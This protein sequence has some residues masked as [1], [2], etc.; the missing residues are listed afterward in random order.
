MRCRHPTAMT[1]AL[2]GGY[3]LPQPMTTSTTA[4]QAPSTQF[5]R[6]NT[7]SN[8]QH[9]KPGGRVYASPA[10]AHQTAGG[11]PELG[12][13]DGH[14]PTNPSRSNPAYG[15]SGDIRSGTNNPAAPCLPA[16]LRPS[17][18]CIAVPGAQGAGCRWAG[19]MN[20]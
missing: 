4:E 19:S 15:I 8:Q 18:A 2:P 14:P 5:G 11:T 10:K 7:P 20:G 1:R 9:A 6:T 17:V 13:L 16:L 12:G 3:S